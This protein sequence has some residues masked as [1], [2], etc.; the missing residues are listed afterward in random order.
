MFRYI[1]SRGS[2]N[3]NPDEFYAPSADMN[4]YIAVIFIPQEADSERYDESIARFILF[5]SIPLV[6]LYNTNSINHKSTTQRFLV[7]V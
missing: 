2:Y 3:Y 4:H 6:E 7:L 1:N 5:R